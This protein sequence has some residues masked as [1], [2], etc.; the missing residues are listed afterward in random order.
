MTS[1]ALHCSRWLGGTSSGGAGGRGG[2]ADVAFRR[3]LLPTRL[4]AGDQ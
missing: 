1:N 2:V 4:V 3:W